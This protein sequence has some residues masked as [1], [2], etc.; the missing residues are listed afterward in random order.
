MIPLFILLRRQRLIR[1]GHIILG[2]LLSPLVAAGLADKITARA[3]E[4]RIATLDGR[5]GLMG[6]A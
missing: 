1:R 3:D 2:L 4:G 5:T 6:T